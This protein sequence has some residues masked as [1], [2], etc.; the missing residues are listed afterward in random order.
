MAFLGRRVRL[1]IGERVR[2]EAF[3]VRV[4]R[5]VERRAEL[6]RER[7]AAVIRTAH[8]N[9]DLITRRLA[10]LFEIIEHR[11]LRRAVAE[12]KTPLFPFGLHGLFDLLKPRPGVSAV[13]EERLVTVVHAHVLGGILGIGFG[14]GEQLRDRDAAIVFRLLPLGLH[15]LVQ[16]LAEVEV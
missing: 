4:E 5:R 9:D 11:S 1:K 8:R 7:E 10:P 3:A 6:P 13:V 14:V 2:E 15:K 16:V 12:K